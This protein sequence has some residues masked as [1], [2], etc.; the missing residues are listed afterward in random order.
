MYYCRLGRCVRKMMVLKYGT[1]VSRLSL[2]FGYQDTFVPCHVRRTDQVVI[3]HWHYENQQKVV[4]ADQRKTTLCV[5][6][7]SLSNHH[8]ETSQLFTSFQCLRSRIRDSRPKV[9]SNCRQVSMRA[10][11]VLSI[12]F[13]GCSLSGLAAYARPVDTKR[14]DDE[15]PQIE[16]A[17][18][19]VLAPVDAS[20]LMT[21]R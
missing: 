16:C 19:F 21:T 5:C 11:T 3:S 14:D 15:R 18:W 1:R 20:L 9:N 17:S 12:L 8:R 7:P 10:T 6:S 13:L 4:T 2:L